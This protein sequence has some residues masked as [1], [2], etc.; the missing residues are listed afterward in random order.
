[1]SRG[2]DKV[3]PQSESGQH[4]TAAKI[5]DVV[6]VPRSDSRCH[7]RAGVAAYTELWCMRCSE[8]MRS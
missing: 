8:A 3:P 6:F 5:G 2:N 1:M 7:G 4:D